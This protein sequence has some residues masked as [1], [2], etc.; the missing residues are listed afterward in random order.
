TSSLSLSLSSSSFS[1]SS[2]STSSHG[3]KRFHFSTT[4]NRSRMTFTERPIGLHCY[5]F[6]RKY[7]PFD[8]ENNFF[9]EFVL[10]RYNSNLSYLAC[11]SLNISLNIIVDLTLRKQAIDRCS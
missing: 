5:L 9:M 7:F 2:L 4:K 10:H 8:Q 3:R 1:L 6:L 11:I